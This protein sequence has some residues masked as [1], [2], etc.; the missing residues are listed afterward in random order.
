MCP[1]LKKLQEFQEKKQNN[2]SDA[3]LITVNENGWHKWGKD[4]DLKGRKY[5][6]KIPT[7]IGK[8]LEV[9]ED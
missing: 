6:K 8:I 9:A 1:E 7:P 5:I 4:G 2:F 3:V